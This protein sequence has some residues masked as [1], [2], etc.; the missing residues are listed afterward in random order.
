MNT[1]TETEKVAADKKQQ[2]VKAQAQL[3]EQLKNIREHHYDYIE[4]VMRV[5]EGGREGGACPQ[6]DCS[7]CPGE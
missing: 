1:E 2:L 7:L 5:C 3:E 6:L 4:K